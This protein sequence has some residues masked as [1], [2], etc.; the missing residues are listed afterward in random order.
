MV[1]CLDLQQALP[2]PRL[3]SN[4]VFYKRKLWTYNFGIHDYKTGRGFMFVW[5]EVTANRGAAEIASCLYKFVTTFVPPTT[6]RLCIF[7]DNCPG[8]NKNYILILFYLFLVHKRLLEEVYH[9]FF[10]TGHTYMAADGHFG[11]CMILIWKCTSH[12]HGRTIGSLE[13]YRCR[14]LY[15]CRKWN[16]GKK[17]YV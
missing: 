15:F 17:K 2:T 12:R 11:K 4:K 10:Q 13:I 8:Q 3:S 16:L 5:D 14:K 6:K 7:S 9:I 1:I